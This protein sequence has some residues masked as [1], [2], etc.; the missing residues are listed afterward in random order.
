MTTQSVKIQKILGATLEN[1][2]SEKYPY[3]TVLRAVQTGYEKFLALLIKADGRVEMT[4][5]WV[6]NNSGRNEP[7]LSTF[8]DLTSIGSKIQA[9]E[10][11]E[12]YCRDNV[13]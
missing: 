9:E 10:F 2:I 8:N 1:E 13:Y 7:K 4:V 11:F 3:V 5:V 12:N 6:S